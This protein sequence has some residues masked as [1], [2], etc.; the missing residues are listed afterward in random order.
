MSIKLLIIDFDNCVY[1]KITTSCL[2][3]T[4]WL[5]VHHKSIFQSGHGIRIVHQS[6]CKSSN[7]D[8][9]EGR[10]IYS[11]IDT[12]QSSIGGGMCFKSVKRG[13]FETR[14]VKDFKPLIKFCPLRSA[15]FEVKPQVFSYILFP[16][17]SLLCDAMAICYLCTVS[18]S[19][20][21]FLII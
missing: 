14:L 12:I 19:K 6:H 21:K 13:R 17:G 10:S 15:F 20:K 8:A 2:V 1:T 16:R 11:I 5:I 4:V 3:S 18:F 7:Y 9:T